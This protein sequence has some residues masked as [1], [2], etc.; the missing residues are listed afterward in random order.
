MSERAAIETAHGDDEDLSPHDKPNLTSAFGRA[1]ERASYGDLVLMA[2]VVLTASSLWFGF[3]PAGQG[4]QMKSRD[5]FDPIYFSVVTFTT[6]GYGDLYPIG[7]GRIF[8]LLDVIVGLA[9]TALL[10]GKVASA[11]QASLLMLL[12]TSDTQKRLADFTEHLARL[13]AR[14]ADAAPDDV[15][16][17]TQILE[18]QPRLIN[19]IRNY[20]IFNTH[21]ATVLQMGSFKALS[22]LYRE[23]SE[24]FALLI[25]MHRRA[26]DFDGA[27]PMRRCLANMEMI[28][29]A[30]R[31]MESLIFPRESGRG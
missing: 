15:K 11:R 1:V 20:L 18:N 22:A 6:V 17:I 7:F 14:L 10:I 21:Q 23:L 27:R 9:F 3:A 16:E 12:H 4:L 31:R 13:R 2:A 30:L 19:G 29:R 25:A 24:C 8:A 28:A 5:G 26:G